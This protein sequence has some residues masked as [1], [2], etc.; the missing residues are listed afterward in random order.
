MKDFNINVAQTKKIC[1]RTL[2]INMIKK[3][4]LLNRPNFYGTKIY[5]KK[6]SEDLERKLSVL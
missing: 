3:S 4:I 1:F 2:I 6:F 5:T